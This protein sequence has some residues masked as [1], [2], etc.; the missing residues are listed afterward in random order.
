MEHLA[1]QGPSRTAY[2]HAPLEYNFA[3]ERHAGYLAAMRKAKI[4]VAP[5]WVV[6]GSLDRRS[7]YAAAQTLLALDPRPTA[8]IV[9]NNIGGIGLIRALLDAKVRI[10]SDISLVVNEG[11][12][13][14]TMFGGLEVA[15]VLQPTPFETGRSIGRMVRALVERKPLA[16]RQVLRQ[17]TFVG[18]NSIGAAP[19]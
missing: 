6:G 12:P 13:A 17:P 8:V 14:D 18:G 7:G 4:K 16:E 1:A 9:D 2:V 15:A 19:R 3:H 5:G 10:G 11:V